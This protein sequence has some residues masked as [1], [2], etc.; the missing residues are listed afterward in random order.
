M[1][2]L[3]NEAESES[4]LTSSD[5]VE[6]WRLLA[7]ED[8]LEAFQDLPRTEAEDFFLE[9]SARDQYDLLASMPKGVGMRR[10][11]MRLLPP[12]DAA[13]L[14]Q[15][16]ADEPERE[17]LLQVLDEQTRREVLALL[18]YAEDEAG[19]LMNPR[20]ARVRP[21]VSADEAI[22][23]LQ[24][25]AREVLE[26]IYYVYVIDADQRLLGVVSFRDLFAAKPDRPVRELM[27][28][29]LVTAREDMDQEE[30]GRLFAQHDLQAIPVVDHAGHMQGIVTVDDIVDVLREEATEDIQKIGGTQALEAPY[31]EVGVVEMVKKRVGW[32]AA[33]FVGE[34]LTTS[35]MSRFEDEIARAVVL[36]IFVP[37]IISSGGNSGSQATTLVIR[38]MALGEVKVMDWFR[39]VRRELVIG[40]IMGVLLGVISFLRTE[41]W[42]LM[43]PD[44]YGPHHLLI[45]FTVALSVAGIVTWGTLAGSTLPFLL[46]MVKL[47]PASASAPFV[48]TLVD[49]TGI[50]IYF[51][52]ASLILRGALL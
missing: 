15:E 36:A 38:A 25:Q 28:T 47:D 16:V 19:G 11:W 8:R 21:D 33:L 2:S 14:I 50:V 17:E 12:D 13:D 27:A 10:S 48:A 5:L 43:F 18:A 20:Y 45:S 42:H 1:T 26:T 22:R 4:G 35:A 49:V 34:M 39:V 3:R 23:Y 44:T 7:P 46:R 52:A 31:L 32:L 37:L 6:T 9:L 40:L 24:R 41:G 29:D 51:T 30:L